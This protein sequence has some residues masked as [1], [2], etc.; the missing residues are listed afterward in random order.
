[1]ICGVGTAAFEQAATRN[2]AA[3]ASSLTDLLSMRPSPQVG[4]R[5]EIMRESPA[6]VSV[7][8]VRRRHNL[9]AVVPGHTARHG[10]IRSME[11]DHASG[12]PRDGAIRAAMNAATSGVLRSCVEDFGGSLEERP[13]SLPAVLDGRTVVVTGR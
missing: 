13:S 6:I 1:M 4:A 12:Y 5:G 8:A 7:P 11:P 3:R 9:D 10:D 2:T